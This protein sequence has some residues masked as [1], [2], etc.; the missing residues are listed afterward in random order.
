MASLAVK[1]LQ[2]RAVGRISVLNR[3][4]SRAEALA[5]RA[6]GPAQYVQSVALN[7]DRLERTW[8]RGDEVHRGG[9]LLVEL[10][11]EPSDWGRNTRPPSAS[12]D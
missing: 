2:T 7:G 10:G 3:S 11:P 1:H 12:A 9:R 6:G 8:L 5:S 4:V